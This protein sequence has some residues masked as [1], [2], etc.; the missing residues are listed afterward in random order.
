M[1]GKLKAFWQGSSRTQ[2]Q[3]EAPDAFRRRYALFQELL[4]SN[5]ENLDLIAD[6][7]EKLRGE[8]LFGMSY[9]RSIAVRSMFHAHRMVKALQELSGGKYSAL[10]QVLEGIREKL[11]KELEAERSLQ[12]EELV[13]SYSRMVMDDLDLVGGKTPVWERQK[14]SSA[15][16]SRKDSQ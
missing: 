2:K 5:A 15:F 6:V 16:L 7:E 1:L 12:R 3:L 9:V 11:R 10:F 8:S 13:L 14:T 4:A